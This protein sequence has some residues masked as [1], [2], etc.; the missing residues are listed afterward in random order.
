VQVENLVPQISFVAAVGEAAPLPMLYFCI[1]HND[2]MLG[3]WDTI[4]DRLYKIRHCMNIEGVVRQLALFAPPIDPAA[5]VKAVAAGLDIGSALADLNAPLPL[6]RFNAILQKANE[7]C[8]DVKALGGAL[9]AA[10]EK[11]DAEALG[12][13][14]Q[15]QELRLLEAVKAVREQ[16]I[17]EAKE[18]LEGVKKNKELA[19]IKQ[20]FYASREFMNAGEITAMALSGASVAINTGIAI[21]YALAGG[22]K[23]VPQF[24]IGAAGFGGS[25]HATGETGGRTFGEIAEDAVATLSAISTALEKGASIASTVAGYERRQDEW[26]FQ[27]D[28]AVKEIEQLEKSIA[29]AE[30]RIAITEKELENQALQIENTQATDAFMRSKYTDQELYQWQVG[31]VSGVYFQSYKLAYDLAKRAERCFRFELGLQESSYI[32]FGYWDSLKKGLLSGEKL[33]YDLRRLETAYLEQN[34]RELELTKHVSLA[35]LDPVALIQ[36][37]ETGRCFFH[38]PE[39]LFDLDYPGHYFRRIKSVGLTLPCVAGPYTTVSCTLR[40]LNNSIR[41]TATGGDT[42]ANHP[43]N[44]ENGSPADDDRF[45]ENNIPVK[46]T[47]MSSAQND[48]GVFELNFRDERYLPFE[49]A[50]AI[51]EWSLELFSDLSSNN[52]D[53]AKPDFGRPLR[54]FDY[55]SISDAILHVKYTAREDAGPFKNGAIAHLR[56]YFEGSAAFSMRIL[57][58]RREFPTQW[59]RFLNPADP[60]NGNV[61]EFEMSPVLFPFRDFGKTLSLTTIALFARGD[62]TTDYAVIMSPPL[63]PPPLPPAADPNEFTVTPV[64]KFGGLHFQQKNVVVQID[65]QAPPMTWRLKMSRADGSNISDPITKVAEINDLILVVGYQWVP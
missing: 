35:L 21:G 4:A 18:N 34:R 59:H 22:L 38:L 60:A 9:L 55:D 28:L 40:L 37:R 52:P 27:K 56:E 54:Q 64:T 43:R 8:N 51:S 23:A 10:L 15:S 41:I 46:T 17:N 65:A 5:L 63:P 47:A 11:K 25:P 45:V 58:L 50:G 39:E 16:Q 33:Q 48:S 53:P 30:L 7:V 62:E 13:L 1:P 61:F 26:D 14:R 32:S 6:Y 19:Q 3:Y 20:L 2:K 31:Q 42:A 49:G 29:A 36:L 44:T 24:I 57:D 12:L